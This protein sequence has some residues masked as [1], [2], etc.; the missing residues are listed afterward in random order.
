MIIGSQYWPPYAGERAFKEVTWGRWPL[1]AISFP[2]SLSIPHTSPR[3]GR[4]ED[5]DS[6]DIA[7][8]EI[9]MN[10]SNAL[11]LKGKSGEDNA[12]LQ[13]SQRH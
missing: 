3:K 11:V 9:M 8:P 1:G 4:N 13:W 6:D 12:W 5:S 10:P 7:Q 2:S